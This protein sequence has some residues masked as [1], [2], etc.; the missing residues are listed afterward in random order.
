MKLENE[1]LLDEYRALSFCECC[2]LP[3]F[4][5]TD[6]HHVECRG[7]GGGSRLDIRIN[8]LGLRRACHDEAPKKKALML[9]LIAQRE[10]TTVEDIRA[11]VALL[12]RLPTDASQT[13]LKR[14]FKELTAD[15]EGLAIKTLEEHQAMTKPRKGARG[16]E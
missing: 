15:Q 1:R 13:V 9:K 4:G 6:P 7:M 11:V 16:R 14:E 12:R 5:K 2:F 10:G 3:T 8:V